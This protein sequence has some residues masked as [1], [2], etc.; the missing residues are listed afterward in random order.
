[1]SQFG[2]QA[3]PYIHRCEPCGREWMLVAQLHDSICTLA[4]NLPLWLC[5][6]LRQ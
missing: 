2:L 6:H 3:I 5:Q 4:S 1:M